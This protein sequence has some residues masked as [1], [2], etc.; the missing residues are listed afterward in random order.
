[1]IRSIALVALALATPAAAFAQSAEPQP[2]VATAKAEGVLRLKSANDFDTTVAKIKADVAAKGIMHFATIDQQALAAGA[3]IK[4]R[5][6][7]LILF[8]NPPLGIQFL[9]ANPLSGL[10]WP[11]RML[12]TEDADGSVTIAWND[13]A[14]IAKRYSITS[15][16]A[17]FKMAT[18]VS[19]SVAKAGATR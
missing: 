12:V 10:D 3:S 8:G 5:R 6:S 2:P 9:T 4:L 15:R 14:W 18:E 19:G 13:F 7:T 17:Q 1:M 16:T 11:V